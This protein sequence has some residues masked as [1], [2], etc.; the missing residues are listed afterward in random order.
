LR[1][2]VNEA[3]LVVERNVLY[4]GHQARLGSARVGAGAA[5]L[6]AGLE[7]CGERERERAKRETEREKPR[8]TLRIVSRSTQLP[9]AERRPHSYP[10]RRKPM[11]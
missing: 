8:T 6:A 9:I 11:H 7:S 5:E 2:L 3:L 1:E 10:S 4:L